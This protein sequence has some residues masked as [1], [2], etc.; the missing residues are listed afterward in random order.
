MLRPGQPTPNE[1]E[2]AIL[3]KLAEK[4]ELPRPPFEHYHV[5]SRKYTIVGSYTN[6]HWAD[7]ARDDQVTGGRLDLEVAINVPGLE[8]GLG[9]I[10]WF[11]KGLP[12]SL[13]I[14][15]YCEERWDGTFEG[16]SIVDCEIQTSQE[17]S[18]KVGESTTRTS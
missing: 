4:N 11:N 8:Y 14:F 12:A 13:E 6:F 10:L 3:R 5:L 17:D 1:L 9:A 16:F 2:L 18:T 15:A 7:I